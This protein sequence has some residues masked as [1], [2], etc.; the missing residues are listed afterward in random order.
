[1]YITAEAVS[2]SYILSFNC[3]PTE[4]YTCCTRLGWC[5]CMGICSAAPWNG[6]QVHHHGCSILSNFLW[7]CENKSETTHP[8]FV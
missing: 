8:F 6:R 5:C 7:S 2:H 1:M 3:R 4:I